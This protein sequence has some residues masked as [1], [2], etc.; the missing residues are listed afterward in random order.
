MAPRA[1]VAWSSHAWLGPLKGALISTDAEQGIY[2]VLRVFLVCLVLAILGLAIVTVAG[3]FGPWSVAADALTNFRVHLAILALFLAAC[4]LGANGQLAAMATVVAVVNLGLAFSYDRSPRVSPTGGKTLKVMT[5]NVLY[6][7]ENDDQIL[8]QIAAEDPDVVFFQELTRAR[9]GLLTRLQTHYP[10]Q[11]SCAGAWRCDVAIV[12]RHRWDTAQA[13][14][15]GAAGTKMA[16]ARFGSEWSNTLVASVHLQ[17]PF[18]SNQMAQLQAVTNFLAGHAGPIIVAG[19]LNAVPWSAAVRSFTRQAQLH[20]AGGFVP[21]WPRRTF[22]EGQPCV[23]CVPQLQIDHVFVSQQFRVLSMR[24]GA[25]VG[26]D[27]LPLIAELELPRTLAAA[28]PSP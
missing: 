13:R 10:W 24:S 17:W 5:V 25:D 18:V 7:V 22:G 4:A 20:S 3:M 15:V 8:A 16:W 27:H 12:S 21:T 23:L 26:S 14:P 1:S 6:R 19:D 28:S 11:I 9:Q 2:Q